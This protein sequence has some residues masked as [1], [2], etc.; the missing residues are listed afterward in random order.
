M[1]AAVL[2]EILLNLLFQANLKHPDLKLNTDAKS[3]WTLEESDKVEIETKEGEISGEISIP[4]KI[5]KDVDA[6]SL[7]LR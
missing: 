3:K 1:I 5:T 6:V 7:K 4:V 2:K